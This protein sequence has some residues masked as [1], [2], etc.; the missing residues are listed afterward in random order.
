M[1][2]AFCLLF[3][4]CAFCLLRGV[5]CLS[6]VSCCLFLVDWY[7][8]RVRCVLFVAVCC[9]LCVCSFGV[10]VWCVGVWCMVRDGVNLV[11]VVRGYP[12]DRFV[13]V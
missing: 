6:I 8:L 2:V 7:L 12:F 4:V 1:F 5:D 11:F 13:L 9:S 10:V 3:V